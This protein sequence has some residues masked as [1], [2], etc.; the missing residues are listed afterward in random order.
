MVGRRRRTPRLGDV[1]EFETS[2]G[3]VYL[4][5]TH[6]HPD[7]GALARV[8]PGAHRERPG[9]SMPCYP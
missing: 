7:F 4:Q 3:R 9:R 8:L 2:R 1:P 5:Y 6:E